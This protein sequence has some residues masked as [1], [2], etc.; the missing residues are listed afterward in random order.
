MGSGP[1]ELH[2]KIIAAFMRGD[3]R[4]RTFARGVIRQAAEALHEF[5]GKAIAEAVRDDGRNWHD[6]AEHILSCLEGP[7]IQRKVDVGPDALLVMLEALD[8]CQWDE[9]ATKAADDLESKHG[10]LDDESDDESDD[11]E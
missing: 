10:P 11:D 8:K 3:R 2:N 4:Q 1:S 7:N 9:W 5:A 6:E